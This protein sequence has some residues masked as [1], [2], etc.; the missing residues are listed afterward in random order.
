[1]NRAQFIA[2]VIDHIGTPYH[3]QGR[4]KGVGVDC[5]GLFVSAAVRCGYEMIAPMDYLNV[6]EQDKLLRHLSEYA[7]PIALEAALAG[8][9]LIFR[10]YHQPQHVGVIV[11]LLPLE[12]VH[13][14]MTVNRVV[15]VPVDGTWAARI[16][17]AYRLKVFDEQ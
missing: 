9:L 12:M 13:T 5:I 8:D 3:H 7:H 17:S 4:L 1:M 10:M 2:E 14:Y 15:R 16:V 6:P 11:N